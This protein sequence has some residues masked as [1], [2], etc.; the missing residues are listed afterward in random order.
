MRS[1]CVRTENCEKFAYSN[2]PARRVTCYTVFLRSFMH[3][4][5]CR[6]AGGEGGLKCRAILSLLARMSAPRAL[7]A[8]A[9]GV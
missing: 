8:A 6:P 2:W 3:S 4:E 5:G 9:C 7:P 1:V